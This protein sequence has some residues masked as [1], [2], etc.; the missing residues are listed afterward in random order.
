VEFTG[1]VY[2]RVDRPMRELTP[3]HMCRYSVLS[4]FVGG[5]SA[6]AWQLASFVGG[7]GCFDMLGDPNF[8]EEP[9]M[10]IWTIR[11]IGCWIIGG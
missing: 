11:R 1:A 4:W 7:G 9:L 3:R 8:M 2:W 6:A 10:V 5:K